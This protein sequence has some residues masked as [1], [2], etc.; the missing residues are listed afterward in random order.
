MVTVLLNSIKSIFLCLQI[1]A[2]PN[3]ESRSE[4]QRKSGKRKTVPKKAP[5]AKKLCLVG[6]IFCDNAILHKQRSVLNLLM[7]KYY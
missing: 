5:A 2:G 6:I 3:L 7:Q 4:G 1:G